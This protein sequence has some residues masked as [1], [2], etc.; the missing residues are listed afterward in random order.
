MLRIPESKPAAE[1]LA[2]LSGELRTWRLCLLSTIRMN[3]YSPLYAF[4]EKNHYNVHDAFEHLCF[5]DKRAMLD[6]LSLLTLFQVSPG[7]LLAPFHVYF[8]TKK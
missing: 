6:L 8:S 7:M 4:H 2:A 5:V 1:T 3:A